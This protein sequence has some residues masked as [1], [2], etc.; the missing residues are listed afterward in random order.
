[1]RMAVETKH[2]NIG[3]ELLL[4]ITKE[5]GDEG[6]SLLRYAGTRRHISKD[7][8]RHLTFFLSDTHT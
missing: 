2:K 7:E 4:W 3:L 1:M 6:R 5:E 8:N